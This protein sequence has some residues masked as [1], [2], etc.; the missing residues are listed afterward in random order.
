MLEVILQIL[1]GASIVAAILAMLAKILPD[2]KLYKWGL[3]IGVAASAFGNKRIPS[4]ERI[5]R[6]LQDSLRAFFVGL[7]DGINGDDPKEEDKPYDDI[8]EPRL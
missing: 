2:D 5:E 7:E 6:F 3:A 4:Y 8:D 1:G